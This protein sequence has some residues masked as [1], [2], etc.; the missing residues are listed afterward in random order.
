MRVLLVTLLAMTVTALVVVG[1]VTLF[2]YG[3]SLPFWVVLGGV[4]A[5]PLAGLGIGYGAMRWTDR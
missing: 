3:R 1:W 2:T 5:M 4:M